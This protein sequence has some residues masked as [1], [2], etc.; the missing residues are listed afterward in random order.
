MY[1]LL[2]VGGASTPHVIVVPIKC[3][4]DINGG[5]NQKMWKIFNFFFKKDFRC[6]KIILS[7][8][9][10]FEC[11]H[12]YGIG[13]F[14]KFSDSN[15]LKLAIY[16]GLIQILKLTNINA[17]SNNITTKVN[18][19]KMGLCVSVLFWICWH[20]VSIQCLPS[21]AQTGYPSK[22]I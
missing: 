3:W 11:P 20:F 1:S 5:P 13:P 17:T 16:Q 2:S 22:L 6:T 4:Y 9:V 12:S 8:T 14:R 7:T 15:P 19:N 21:A 10:H 18:K